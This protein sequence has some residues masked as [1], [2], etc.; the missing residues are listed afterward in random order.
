[1]YDLI[2]CVRGVIPELKWS[3]HFKRKKVT[4]VFLNRL[5]SG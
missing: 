5:V 1:M 4:E 3:E 2:G